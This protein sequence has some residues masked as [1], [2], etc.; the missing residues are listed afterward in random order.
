M[1]DTS[2]QNAQAYLDN[3][4][5]L[6][7]ASVGVVLT[8]TR[9]PFRVIGVLRDFAQAN[10][11]PFKAWN[12]VRG[13][14]TYKAGSNQV[15]NA[16]Q[17]TIDPMA[18]LRALSNKENSDG[19][20]VMMYPHYA[21]AADGKVRHPGMVQ[22]IKEYVQDF[23]AC[24]KRLFLITPHD[25]AV[26][27]ELED[28]MTIIDFEPPA[29]VER[30]MLYH[31]LM[32]QVPADKRPKFSKEDLN[33]INA[34]TA[35]MTSHEVS[36]ALARALAA[37]RSKLP[38]VDVNDFL[39]VLASIKTEAIRRSEVL[40]LME[41]ENMANIGGLDMLKEWIEKRKNCFTEEAKAFGVDTP[42]GIALIGPPGTGK[43]LFAKAIANG[44][45][46]PLIRFDVSRVFNSLVGSSEARVRTALKMVD[47]LAPCVLMID[48][49][50][51]VFQA[52]GGNGDSGV[53]QRVLGALLTWMNDTKA[54]VF[55][56]VTANRVDN[57][58]AEFLRKGR[59]DEVF[60]VSLPSAD[61]RLE[62]IKIHLRKRGKNP[63]TIKDLEA[64]VERSE[65]YVPAEI[66]AAVKEAIL[67]AFAG[68][69]ELNGELVAAQ[70]ANMKPLSESFADQFDRMREWA[71]NNARP[72]NKGGFG[73]RRETVTAGSDGSN[74]SG[75][76]LS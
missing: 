24:R 7:K 51:K 64:A 66:E 3:I 25:F 2:N 30:T 41:S 26:P 1:S 27:H 45:R 70:L 62:I 43:S 47:S 18:A 20:Y 11:L 34:I 48:E 19:I 52:N 61:E 6:H 57:L 44:L 73:Q 23:A 75:L 13:W 59:L 32:D 35:G 56:V 29:A 36:S 76:D 74:K 14:T 8:R 63:D 31:R 49:V 42:K 38:N 72:A 53:S 67:E 15:E 65:G 21:L 54:P 10:T 39:N 5:I 40:E 68:D 46:K 17:N 12:V 22:L 16:D 33:A 37:N 50:D 9:E 58:P 4:N 71:E 55:M 28:D 60:S 69:L